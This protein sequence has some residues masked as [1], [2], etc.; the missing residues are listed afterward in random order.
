MVGLF[1]QSNCIVHVTSL[2][3][4]DLFGVICSIGSGENSMCHVAYA[5]LLC[6]AQTREDYPDSK[7][8]IAPRNL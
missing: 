7:H 1:G 5:R 2:W 3:L 8:P 4:L 6:C